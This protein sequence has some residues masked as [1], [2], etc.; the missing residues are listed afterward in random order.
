MASKPTVKEIQKQLQTWYSEAKNFRN[1]GWTQKGYREKI[2]T[3]H[4]DVNRLMD[5]LTEAEETEKS[6]YRKDVRENGK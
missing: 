5:N 4:A 1:D 2:E 3:L 6:T